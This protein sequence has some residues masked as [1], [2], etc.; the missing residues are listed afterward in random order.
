MPSTR[1]KNYC[2]KRALIAS[3]LAEQA[4][5]EDVMDEPAAKAAVEKAPGTVAA[6]GPA[7]DPEAVVGMPFRHPAAAPEAD[8]PV[9]WIPP[10]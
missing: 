3:A 6:A 8:P 1:K 9:S 7:A 4:A 10:L 2:K 5:D